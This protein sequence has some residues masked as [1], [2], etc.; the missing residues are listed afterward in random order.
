MCIA[1]KVEQIRNTFVLF[2]LSSPYP[3]KLS[4]PKTQKEEDDVTL[5][6]CMP[7]I[8]THLYLLTIKVLQ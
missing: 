6:L 7:T 2:V 5:K 8:T 3:N 4:S 1:G